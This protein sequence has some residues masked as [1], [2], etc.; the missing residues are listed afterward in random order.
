MRGDATDCVAGGGRYPFV[1]GFAAG[2]YRSVTGA[3]VTTSGGPTFTGA[4][5]R[6]VLKDI[7]PASLGSAATLFHTGPRSPQAPRQAQLILV[8]AGTASR[9]L[10]AGAFSACVRPNALAPRL[11]DDERE[12]HAAF[13][14]TLGDN[15][16]WRE[17]WPLAAD[18]PLVPCAS[19]P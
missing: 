17:Y 2:T 12:T 14:A 5:I 15:A 18:A 3:L 16:I 11:S 13:I 10:H 8:D 4:V 6:T 7:A 9:S 1:Q 19:S